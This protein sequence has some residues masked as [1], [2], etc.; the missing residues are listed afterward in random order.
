MARNVTGMLFEG[1]PATGKSTVI[2]ELLKSSAITERD[3]MPF[4]TFG[5]DITQRVLEA[6]HNQGVITIDDNINLL[7]SDMIRL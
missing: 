5:E 1:I 2:K 4:F 7:K 6:K 3:F